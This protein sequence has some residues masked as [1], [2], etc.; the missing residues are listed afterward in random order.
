MQGFDQLQAS[1]NRAVALNR[2]GQTWPHVVV[3][4]PSLSLGEAVLA[5]YGPRLPALEHRYLAAFF[6]LH[7]IPNAEVIYVSTLPPSEEVMDYCAS[8]LPPGGDA[9]TRFHCVALRDMSMRGVA[10]KLL[11]RP[12]LIAGIR[13]RIG[14]RPAFLEPWNVTEA[15]ARLALELGV[16]V[17]GSDPA[18]WPLGF[19]SAGRRLLRGAGV[20]LPAGR[21]DLTEVEEV[22][23]AIAAL[24]AEVPGL[25]RVIVKHDDSAAGDGN[26]VV[27]LS[28]APDEAALRA[29]LEGFG[30]EYWEVLA[31]GGVVEEMIE[32]ERFASP[33]VQVDIRPD[34]NVEVL[35]THE[36][37]LGGDDGQVY[38]GCRFPAEP[39]YAP[40]LAAHGQQVGEALAKAGALG[41][42]ALDFAAVEN[43]GAWRAVALEINLR[44]G[45]TTHPYAVLRNLVPGRYDAEAGLWRAEAGGTRAYVADDNVVDP[46]WVSLPPAEAI[47]RVREAGLQFDSAT[48]VGVV[49]LM[50]SGL[51]ID[52]RFATVAIGRDGAEAQRLMDRVGA[53]MR[54]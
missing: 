15:E 3:V 52:G 18:L 35:A 8:L 12:D 13:E 14:G 21:E 38:V 36:Q 41:R 5:H 48:G 54:A 49:L 1:L 39:A 42:F 29:R 4:L 44:K 50:L 6:L 19:K 30:P 28:D 51:A 32:G 17:N 23:D 16:P 7:R 37:V 26:R 53:A 27:D 11:D 33:S 34:G 2:P 24:R 43:E 20:P 31:R 22:L 45:G 25:R 10:E 40:E 46:A 47:R 9:R